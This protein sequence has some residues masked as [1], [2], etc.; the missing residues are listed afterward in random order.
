PRSASFRLFPYTTLFRSRTGG[1]RVVG[2]HDLHG[3]RPVR[4]ASDVPLALERS[5]LVLD[6]RRAG[7]P[8]RVAD[9]THRGC[10]AACL[11]RRADA[12]PEEHTSEL[13]SRCELAC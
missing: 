13:Q 1:L 12:R 3:A 11:D 4:V 6:A 2:V 5:E 7:E 8:D 9:R 10:V